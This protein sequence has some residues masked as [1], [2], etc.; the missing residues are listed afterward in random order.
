V[1]F[2]IDLGGTKTEIVALDADDREVLRRRVSTPAHDYDSI[3]ATIAALVATAERELGVAG[4]VGVATPGA[5]SRATGRMKNAN[6]TVLIDRDLAADLARAL[7]RPVRIANDANCFALSEAADGAAVGALCVFGVIIGTGVGGGIVCDGRILT[8]RNDI[9]GEWGHNA[10]PW[11]RDD[12]RPGPPCYC[13]KAGCIETFVSGTGFRNDHR[14]QGGEALEGAAIVAAANAGATEARATLERYVDR[15]ARAL[16]SVVNVLD[17][18]A[19]VLGGGMSNV[20]HVYDALPQRMTPYVFSDT[21]E[22]PIVRPLHGDS[23]GVRGAARL[24]DAP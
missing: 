2:G 5:R 6:S 16:A 23:S 22:T 24:W 13:G 4:R 1:R 11:P 8:G 19:I 21:F 10:L 7:D 9:A 12:E 18:D 20:A 3:V 17:P 15:L 14:R